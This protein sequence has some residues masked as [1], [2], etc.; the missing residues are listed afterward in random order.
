[1]TEVEACWVEGGAEAACYEAAAVEVDYDW[2][3][4]GSWG[5]VGG[6]G[7]DLENASV[8]GRQGVESGFVGMLS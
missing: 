1:M 2:P 4:G 7:P 3:G 5:F 6:Y 8:L